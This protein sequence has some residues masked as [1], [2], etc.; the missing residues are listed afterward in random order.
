MIRAELYR[1]ED[2]AV[3]VAIATGWQGGAAIEPVGAGVEGLDRLL[4]ATPVVVDDP[5]LRPL[6]AHGEVVLPPGT[7]EWFR[8]ALLVR[9]GD[10]GLGVRFVADEVRNG[11]DPAANYRTFEEQIRRLASS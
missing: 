6:G 5:S 11:W 10:A 2:P 9:G 7:L 4:R 8:T 1:P 3:V